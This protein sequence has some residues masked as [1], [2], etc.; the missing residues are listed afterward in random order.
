MVTIMGK[1]C[2]LLQSVLYYNHR[3]EGAKPMKKFT[4]HEE[5]IL[6]TLIQMELKRNKE[7]E[8]YDIEPAFKNEE[9]R[10]LYEK[11]TGWKWEA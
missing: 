5:I 6:A 8:A 3:K 2:K 1:Y 7:C 4:K 10:N 11:V 9:L